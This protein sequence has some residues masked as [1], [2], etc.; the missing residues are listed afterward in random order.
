MKLDISERDKK[1][2]LLLLI[3]AIIAVPYYFLIQPG[4]NQISD[5]RA[6]IEELNAEKTRLEGYVRRVPE[7]REAIEGYV[8]E[9]GQILSRYPRELP[10]E[11]TIIFIDRTEK[12]LPI[13]LQS[14]SFAS[15]KR[16]PITASMANQAADDD[17][18]MEL[19]QTKVGD[20]LTGIAMDMSFNFTSSYQE[21]KNFLNY[22]LN[23][24]DRMVISRMSARENADTERVEGTFTMTAYAIYGANRYP[25][26]INIPPF[27]LGTLNI[28]RLP[29]SF[30]YISVLPLAD[31]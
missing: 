29:F 13:R 11:A 3:V 4:I 24:Q 14:V 7:Y 19:G 2:L 23:H 18:E 25:V 8:V 28:F 30:Q 10:Q 27:E 9:I 20:L 15:E 1:L 22:I 21:Y 6:E 17:E 5:M 12:Q 31:E 26:N 16:S